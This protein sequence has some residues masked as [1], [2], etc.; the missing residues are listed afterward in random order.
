MRLATQ[1]IFNSLQHPVQFLFRDDQRRSQPD[2]IAVGLLGQHAPLFQCL[3]EATRTSSLRLEHNTDEE[4]SASA[5]CH[6]RAFDRLQEFI[7]STIS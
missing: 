4:P 5:K 2:D 6:V 1:D 3:A 7:G